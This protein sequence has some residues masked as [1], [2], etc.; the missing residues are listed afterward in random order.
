MAPDRSILIVDHRLDGLVQS[1]DR[2]VVL[3]RERT[4]I[5]DGPPRTVFRDKRD[6]LMMLGIWC[7]AS[8]SL[9]AALVRA[10]LASPVPPLSMDEALA[11]LDPAVAPTEVIEKA[12]PLVEAFVTASFASPER[13]VRQTAVVA[14]LAGADCAPFMGPVVLRDIDVHIH[15]GEILGILGANGVGKSTL[16]LCLA[17]LLAPRAGE[18]TGASGGFAFQRPEN[19][20]VT[21]SVR[22]EILAGL[23][24]NIGE[25]KRAERVVA[26]L[27]EW[28]LAG[29][30]DKHPFEL[31]EG[32]KRRLAIATLSSSDRWPLL[33]LDEPMAGLDARGVSTLID[34]LRPLTEKGRAIAVITH[35]MDLALRLCPRSIVLGEGRI[36]ADGP[37]EALMEDCSLLSRA[38]LTEPSCASARRWLRR[39]SSC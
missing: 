28:D 14:R 9:D 17:G 18:R 37:T 16:G 5:A 8:S 19:Q 38:G 20:F 4:I 27:G 1:I 2:V 23:P 21:G 32:Q 39:V 7:P 12:R 15:E 6:L 25:E 34:R 24:L 33:V 36:L 26:T 35:D 11:P 30:D 10:G 13:T 3:G 31:S 29:L 22:A